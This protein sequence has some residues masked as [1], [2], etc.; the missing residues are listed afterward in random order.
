M[1]ARSCAVL[2]VED[3]IA[4]RI[5]KNRDQMGAFK[6]MVTIDRIT[7][8]RF[9][10]ED[11]LS[12]RSFGS[13]SFR[14]IESRYCNWPVEFNFNLVDFGVPFWIVSW[15]GAGFYQLQS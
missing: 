12:L 6:L 2:F 8:L 5:K 9:K 4:R 11:T 13:A 3:P 7:E 1:V 14:L 10:V 15:P